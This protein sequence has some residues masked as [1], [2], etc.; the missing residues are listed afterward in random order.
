MITRSDY[1]YKC[2]HDLSKLGPRYIWIPNGEDY[3]CVSDRHWILNQHRIQ[4]NTS[5]SVA[6]VD[7]LLT[8]I[9]HSKQFMK[10]KLNGNPKSL[11]KHVWHS[12]GLYPY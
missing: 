6:V 12:Q 4:N 5:A 8:V 7:I 11:I 3:G 9:R 1:V 10:L 2:K